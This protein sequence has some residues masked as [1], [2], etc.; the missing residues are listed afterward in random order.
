MY[1]M[2]H[3]VVV[4]LILFL[5]AALSL[6]GVLMDPPAS[7][8]PPVLSLTVPCP[9]PVSN[10]SL[11][12][13]NSSDSRS[14]GSHSHSPSPHYRYRSST[15]P[16][17]APV[18]LASVSSH[19]SGFVSHDACQSKSPSPMPSDS[20]PQV[21][22]PYGVYWGCFTCTVRLLDMCHV[23]WLQNRSMDFTGLLYFIKGSSRVCF[24]YWH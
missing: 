23:P 18:R 9:I 15:L 6:C 24:S 22:P 8:L 12:S 4:F 11:N 1:S 2:R 7:P 14:S 10:S 13:V 19:D 21:R 20:V 5:P 3:I 16:Q 17:Q